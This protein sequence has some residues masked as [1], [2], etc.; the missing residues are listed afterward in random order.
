VFCEV[1]YLIPLKSYTINYPLLLM[2]S[3]T[4]LDYVFGQL[5]VFQFTKKWPNYLNRGKKLMNFIYFEE[6]SCLLGCS[7]L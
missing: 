6:E 5:L 7:A 4:F 3:F 2:L 1:I